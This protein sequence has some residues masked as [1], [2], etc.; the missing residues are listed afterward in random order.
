MLL[1]NR[2]GAT[3]RL[4]LKF[5]ASLATVL[6]VLPDGLLAGLTTCGED[7]LLLVVALEAIGSSMCEPTEF[8]DARS[9]AGTH[10]TIV[11]LPEGVEVTVLVSG[12]EHLLHITL[13]MEG[14]TPELRVWHAWL[15]TVTA[16]TPQG[17]MANLG[18]GPADAVRNDLRG[19][20]AVVLNAHLDITLAVE[21]TD[22][23]RP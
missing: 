9:V 8:G 18:T 11:I 21:S 12:V 22:M 10:R 6:R 3:G 20:P 19:G 13:H 23:T 2:S 1:T 15:V 17:P 16:T 5:W 7:V 4:S 14:N